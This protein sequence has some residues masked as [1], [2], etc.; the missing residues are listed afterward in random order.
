MLE[1]L[2]VAKEKSLP[3]M[4]V[5]ARA[6]GSVDVGAIGGVQLLEYPGAD[7]SAIADRLVARLRE[8]LPDPEVVR[9]NRPVEPSSK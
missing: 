1:L 5:M 9:I 7:S 2:R 6:L 8:I 4:E 3:Y